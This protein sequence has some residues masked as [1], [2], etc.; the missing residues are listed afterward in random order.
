[1]AMRFDNAFII[2]CE[3]LWTAT[4]VTVNK[5]YVV[6]SAHYQIAR[7]TLAV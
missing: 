5:M 2:I 4:R 7:L 3:H 1:M 6:I